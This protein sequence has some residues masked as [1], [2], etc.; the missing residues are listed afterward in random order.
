MG[1]IPD[2]TNTY[3][4]ALSDIDFNPAT[5]DVK[6]FMQSTK[7]TNWFS[8]NQLA[9]MCHLAEINTSDPNGDLN[10]CGWAS[11]PGKTV[12]VNGVPPVPG[13]PAPVFQVR[14]G[15][16]VRLRLLNESISRDFRLTLLNN[17]TGSKTN[18][19]RIG[20]QGGLLNNVRVEGGTQGLWDTKFS[21]GEIDIGPGLR[22]DVMFYPNASAPPGT[23]IQL[24]GNPLPDPF[25]YSGTTVSLNGAPHPN[26]TNNYPIA[27]FQIV[28]TLSPAETR[29]QQRRPNPCRH[30]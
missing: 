20:G 19:F 11:A 29:S 18:L 25:K 9:E 8:I 28:G 4:L 30:R 24:V 13:S 6:R 23:I 21:P 17:G 16:R 7:Q 22:A 26:L 12:L 10:A 14:A 15:Q 1:R 2:P 5:G 27:Y 3:T